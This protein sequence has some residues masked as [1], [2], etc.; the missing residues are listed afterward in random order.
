MRFVGIVASGLVSGNYYNVGGA[1]HIEAS[2][3]RNLN[4][5]QFVSHREHSVIG[6]KTT[7]CDRN[8]CDRLFIVQ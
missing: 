5:I 6:V 4:D 8:V 7:V 3:T 2:K 1:S